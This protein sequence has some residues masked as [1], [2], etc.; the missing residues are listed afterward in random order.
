VIVLLGGLLFVAVL[1]LE[2]VRKEEVKEGEG[3]CHLRGGLC[4]QPELEMLRLLF[5]LS[6]L[7]LMLEKEERD[8]IRS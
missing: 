5:L 6:V 2:V 1:G 8:P 4:K 3:E 7:L